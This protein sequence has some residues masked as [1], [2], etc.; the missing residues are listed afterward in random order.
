[1]QRKSLVLVAIAIT[2]FTTFLLQL[3]VAQAAAPQQSA[4]PTAADEPVALDQPLRIQIRQS[5]PFTISLLPATALTATASLTPAVDA[6]GAADEITGSIALTDAGAAITPT[7]EADVLTTTAQITTPAIVNNVVVTLEI[8]LD[9]LVTQTLTTTVPTSVTLQVSGFE[10]QTIPVD[11][12]IAP[13]AEG[14]AVVE[15]VLPAIETSAVTETPAVTATGALTESVVATPTVTAILSSEINGVPLINTTATVTSNLRAG[16]GTTFNVVSQVGPGETVQIAAISEDGQWYL[17]GNGAWIANFLV[18]E[19]PANAPVVNDEILQA[20][21]GVAPTEAATP[22]ETATPTPPTATGVITPTVTTDANLRSGPGT[23]FDAIG[24]TVI[25]QEINIVG[26]NADGTWFRLDNGGWVFGTLVANPP[27]LDSIPVVDND[28]A[29]L[30]PAATPAA[31]LGGLLPTPTP[32]AQAS[33]DEVAAYLTA[34]GELIGQFDLVLNSVDALLAEVNSNAA[35]I[36]DP[37]WTTRMN[38]ALTLLRRTSASV[39]ELTVPDAA[40]TVHQQLEKAAISY[41]AAADALAQAVRAGDIGLLGETDAL[42]STAA[43]NL[44]TAESAIAQA[45]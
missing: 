39:G 14:E 12:V 18:A 41:A 28:G 16:P 13:L 8:E 3:A 33:A 38:A 23:N 20:V 19:Q 15:L 7:I 25:G 5:L 11:V 27:A 22:A 29:P 40:A 21:Q 35:L 2:L 10:T 4:A 17:L 9:F 32:P 1:M 34:A 36:S 31:G 6:L 37:A 44:T 43:A 30:E 42:V 26:R 45:Q 24:G